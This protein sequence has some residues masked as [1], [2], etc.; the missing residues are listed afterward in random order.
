MEATTLA[1]ALRSWIADAT[2]LRPGGATSLV[3]LP[4]ASTAL[5]YRRTPE[6]RGDL[7]VIG[8][9]SRASYHP[10]DKLFTCV[11]VRLRPGVAR[12]LLGVPV[13]GLRDRSVALTDLWGERA[14]RVEAELA[15]LKDPAAIL[16]GLEE[17]LSAVPA[18]TGEPEGWTAPYGEDA[19]A[20]SSNRAD[21]GP[22]P[23]PY[24]A[25]PHRTPPLDGLVRAAVAALA[26]PGVRFAALAE[27]L[28]VS[29]RRLRDLFTEH[30][31]LAPKQYAR[32]TRVRA[33]LAGPEGAGWAGVA[34][35]TGYYDQSHM[36]AD[37]RALMGVPP[38]AFHAGRLPTATPCGG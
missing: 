19:G 29:E 33:V 34:V 23:A 3:H 2:L 15:A 6:G 4:D 32:I 9:R 11:R 12:Q 30:V 10:D 17:A 5:A 20:R 31:G 37:F 16:R 22:L 25:E 13:A 7:R 26:D 38:A 21:R 18:P 28:E 14:A 1:P 8:P 36:T 24:A 35:D 27:R